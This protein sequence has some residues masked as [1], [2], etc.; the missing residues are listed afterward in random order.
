VTGA[1]G[2]W[3]SQLLSPAADRVRVTIRADTAQ[4]DVSLP[5]DVSVAVLT[6]SVV[7]L[8]TS[9]AP[10]VAGSTSADDF[11]NTRWTIRRSPCGT[12][13][14]AGETLRDAGV[15]A[16]G[17]LRLTAERPFAPPTHYDDVVD[18]AAHLTTTG[19]RG[20]SAVAARNIAFGGVYLICAAWLYLLLS[21]AV[22]PNRSTVIGLSAL[23]AVGL[24]AAAASG[25]RSFGRVDVGIVLGWAA[26]VLAAAIG[27]AVFRPL[28][29]YPLAA[30]CWGLAVIAWGVH[31]LTGV[32]RGGYLAAD[33]V[34]AVSGVLLAAHAAGVPTAA[35]GAVTAVLCILSCSAVG[36]AFRGSVSSAAESPDLWA[37]ITASRWMRAGLYAG[38]A[39]SAGIGAGSV[40][41]AAGAAKWPALILSLTCAAA[42][43]VHSGPGSSALERAALRTPAAVLAAATCVAAGQTGAQPVPLV[44]LVAV[45]SVCVASV[46][47]G[48][49]GLRSTQRRTQTLL[50]HARYLLTAALIP[51]L[52]WV[53]GVFG[54]GGGG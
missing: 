53:I 21:D 40:L 16:G 41:F 14:D 15:V 10:D 22:A 13:L 28:G 49:R 9:A 48:L 12:P 38:L 24:A 37:T 50:A 42:L 27:W 43:T 18:A 6:D 19:H 34:L 2:E 25:A 46:V 31:I 29:E 5:L 30:A 26:V 4:A 8:L 33:L 23:T 3:D 54:H 35:L 51:L 52:L 20:W 47:A 45:M 44:T 11:A 1:A 17:L 39:V 7:R 32:G 36:R